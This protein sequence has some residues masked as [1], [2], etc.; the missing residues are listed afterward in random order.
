MH[1]IALAIS[2][3]AT[4]VVCVTLYRHGWRSRN[5]VI[6]VVV[7]GLPWV[8]WVVGL[9]WIACVA[10]MIAGAVWLALYLT[11]WGPEHT[12]SFV[13]VF[14][15]PWVGW[16][17]GLPWIACVALMIAG[18]I[19]AVR[20]WAS[21]QKMGKRLL[22]KMEERLDHSLD[23][24]TLG[25]PPPVLPPWPKPPWGEPP[26]VLPPWP[27][28][29]PG[30]Q[31]RAAMSSPRS[32]EDEEDLSEE[33]LAAE[34]ARAADYDLRRASRWRRAIRS[35]LQAR[36]RRRGRGRVAGE[37]VR[38]IYFKRQPRHLRR[39]PRGDTP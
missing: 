32:R 36:E 39:R 5:Q 30:S 14:G 27:E 24:L 16:V 28:P 25:E 13:V 31:Y 17:M 8:G 1:W 11:G 18:V 12:V 33:E 21:L 6:V 3:V 29:P 9:P 10:L 19:V 37:R 23:G 4:V 38:D 26:P 34:Y 20:S 22:Q 2:A 7:F 15:L 35:I